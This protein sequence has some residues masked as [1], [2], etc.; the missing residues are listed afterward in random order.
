MFEGRK[1]LVIFD[2]TWHLQVYF[3]PPHLLGMSLWPV[4]KVARGVL[5]DAGISP[6]QVVQANLSAEVQLIITHVPG[7][8]KEFRPFPLQLKDAGHARGAPGS[9]PRQWALLQS[10]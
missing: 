9:S 6:G 3:V 7:T 2:L 10:H 8:Y 1:C 4:S 5:L